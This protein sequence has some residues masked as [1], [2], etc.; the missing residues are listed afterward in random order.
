MSLPAT[1]P[2]RKQRFEAALKLAGL[3]IER[4]RTEV[5]PVSWTHLDMVLNGEREGSA[6]L[7]GAIDGLIATHLTPLVN[8]AD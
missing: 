4:W 6:A 8:A 7:N 2:T 5:Y 1:V 3:T